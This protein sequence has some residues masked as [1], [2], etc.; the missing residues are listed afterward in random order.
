MENS[1]S[2]LVNALVG[3]FNI[4]YTKIVFIPNGYGIAVIVGFIFATIICYTAGF[5]SYT[6]VAHISDNMVT[7]GLA[8]TIWNHYEGNWKMKNGIKEKC[9]NEVWN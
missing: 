2:I 1:T 9:I 5:V 6:L 8:D 4:L 7:H 3:S